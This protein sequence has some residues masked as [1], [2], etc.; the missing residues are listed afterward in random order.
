ML[1]STLLLLLLLLL[2]REWHIVA[3]GIILVVVGLVGQGIGN[4][5]RLGGVVA[6]A[7]ILVGGLDRFVIVRVCVRGSVIRMMLIIRRIRR[8]VI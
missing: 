2:V 4:T 1:R 8:R 6:D 3:I 7:L 5:I